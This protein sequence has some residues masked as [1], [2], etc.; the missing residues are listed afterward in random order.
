MA[1][2]R[3]RR[4]RRLR[5]AAAPGLL[6][7]LL[8]CAEDAAPEQIVRR[9]I[10]AALEAARDRDVGDV[11][12]HV[13]DPFQGPRGS[14]RAEV[15]RVVAGHFLR[16]GWMTVFAPRVDVAAAEDGAIKAT[17]DLV[18]ARGEPVESLEDVLPSRADRFTLRTTS[19][20]VDGTWRFVAAEI[21][22]GPALPR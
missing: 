22:R 5:W 21:D 18:M 20:N 14:S 16:S 8:A 13:A 12:E 17:I 10:N 7:G 4:G 19:R 11:F 6:L 15:K 1:S 9:Q 2:A 3:P